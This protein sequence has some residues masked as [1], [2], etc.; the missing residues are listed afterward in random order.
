MA[1]LLPVLVFLLPLLITPGILFHY[2]ITPKVVI[3]SVMVAGCLS[4][5]GQI[6]DSIAALW[7]RKTGRWLCAIAAA[8]AI[9]YA[10]AASLSSRPWFSL[11]GSNWRR[12]GLSTVVAL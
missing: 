4:F 3:L 2:D 1:I 7:S 8:Q 5:P 6:S 10:V 11:L 12:M 9:W